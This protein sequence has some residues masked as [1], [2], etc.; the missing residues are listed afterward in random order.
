MNLKSFALGLVLATSVG[1]GVAAAAD[2]ADARLVG[3]K[4]YLVGDEGA[5]ACES[6]HEISPLDVD[7]KAGSFSR[8]VTVPSSVPSCD[9]DAAFAALNPKIT[10]EAKAGVA[11]P[12]ATV[13]FPAAVEVK[14]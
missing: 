3:F 7:L 1:V 5:C 9:L 12:E 6:F 4:C 10:P 2:K 8:L 11:W 13:A 14:P